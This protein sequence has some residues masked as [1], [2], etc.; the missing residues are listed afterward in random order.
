[1]KKTIKSLNEWKKNKRKNL[2][3]KSIHCF[4]QNFKIENVV[5]KLINI[6]N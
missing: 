6:L 5:K 2:Y 3:K 1:L 4:N